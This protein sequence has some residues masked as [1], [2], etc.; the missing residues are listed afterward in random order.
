MQYSQ[1]ERESSMTNAP[2]TTNPDRLRISI[3]NATQKSTRDETQSYYIDAYLC[4]SYFMYI[5]MQ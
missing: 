5:N 4:M 1:R 2:I 3:S